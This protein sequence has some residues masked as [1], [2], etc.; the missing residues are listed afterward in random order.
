MQVRVRIRV[1]VDLG[2]ALWVRYRGGQVNAYLLGTGFLSSQTH[3]N[4]HRDLGG[5]R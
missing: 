2:L 5:R 1:R 3:K 4:N